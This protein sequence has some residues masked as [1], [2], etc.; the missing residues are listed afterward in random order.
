M[1]KTVQFTECAKIFDKVKND[2]SHSH[3]KKRNFYPCKGFYSLKQAKH[4]EKNIF[5]YNKFQDP[6]QAF[7]KSW[8]DNERYLT[9]LV[10]IKRL[11]FVGNSNSASR[12]MHQR[13]CA[14]AY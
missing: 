2:A 8:S 12:I 11:L 14:R 4:E 9:E 6:V 13:R 1:Y 5:S 3:F 10:G 7:R